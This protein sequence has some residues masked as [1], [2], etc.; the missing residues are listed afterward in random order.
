MNF[1]KKTVAFWFVILLISS[2]SENNEA[3]FSADF[4][5][6]FVDDNH[7]KFLNQSSG[8]YYSIQWN[9]GNGQTLETT[10]KNKNPEIYYPAAG[11][12]QVTLT[13]Q[14]YTGQ[15]KT[16]SKSLTITKDD[17]VLSFTAEVSPSDPNTVNLVNTST[18]VF[19]SFQWIFRNREVEK[20][21]QYSAYFPFQ[22]QFDITLEVTRNGVPFS[23]KKTVNITRD[24]PGYAEKL[25]L[26]WSDEFDGS[27]VNT[28]N[29]KFETG[30]TGW[31]NNELQ[32]YTNGDNAAV[33]GGK[34]IITANKDG[35]KGKVTLRNGNLAG[36]LDAGQQFPDSRLAR[37]WRD[38]YNGICGISAQYRT[39]YGT[40]AFGLW[41]CR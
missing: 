18:G 33:T 9:F 25:V 26:K 3:D 10:D 21:M 30:A 15:V 16:T 11:N 29:W 32:N 35:G 8:E 19:D 4:T 28:G 22:G 27:A 24:D 13:L 38:R 31:G 41:K 36:S 23:L 12:Y 34:L 20:V 14:N 5:M 6:E 40:Y 39:C 2:C 37:M 1:F 7:V 17:L